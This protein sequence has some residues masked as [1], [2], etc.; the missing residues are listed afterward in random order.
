MIKR[1]CP[2][3]TR[4]ELVFGVP[5]QTRAPRNP[6]APVRFLNRAERRLKSVAK[7]LRQAKKSA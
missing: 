5:G 4:A 7:A 3:Q 6:L 2:V 1:R